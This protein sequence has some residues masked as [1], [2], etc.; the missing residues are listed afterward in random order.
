LNT[1][2]FRPAPLTDKGLVVIARLSGGKWGRMIDQARPHEPG[3]TRD[4][5]YERYQQSMAPGISPQVLAVR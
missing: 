3:P 2:V 1:N 5:G 4:D